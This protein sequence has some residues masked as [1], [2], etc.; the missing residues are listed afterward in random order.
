MTEAATHVAH[1]DAS[2]AAHGGSSGLRTVA[3]S[4]WSDAFREILGER[5]LRILDVGAGDGEA[6]LLLHRIGHYPHG[7]D[8]DAGQVRAARSKADACCAAAPFRVGD[9]E[10]LDFPA[11]VFDAVHA[12]DLLARLPHPKWA[13]AEWFRVLRPHGIVVVA[14]S[15]PGVNASELLLS[16]GFHDVQS[17]ELGRL[18]ACAAAD[19]RGA[20][21]YRRLTPPSRKSWTVAWGRRS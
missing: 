1:A 8:I 17:R 3:P 6:A 13:L 7:V 15:T 9:A 19:R 11:G 4:T 5:P 12:R 21:W 18:A 10:N 16:T 14:E 2:I 20:P